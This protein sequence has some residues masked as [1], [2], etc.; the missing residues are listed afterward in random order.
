MGEVFHAIDE[1]LG[2]PVAVKLMLPSGGD[3]SSAERFRREARA[4]ARLSDPHLVAVYDFGQ[5]GDQFFLVMELVEGHTVSRYQFRYAGGHVGHCTHIRS[6]PDQRDESRNAKHLAEAF[7]K[8]L[9]TSLDHAA[10]AVPLDRHSV[11]VAERALPEHTRYPN[12]PVADAE[13][14][15]T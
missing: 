4:A 10:D 7:A 15:A 12:H 1:Q 3:S 13:P 8:Q 5:Q 11:P 14:L 9:A 2:R 6:E